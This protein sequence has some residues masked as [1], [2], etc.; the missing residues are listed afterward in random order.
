MKT[1]LY[2]GDEYMNSGHVG[3][4]GCGATVAMKLALRALGEHT[5]MVIPASCWAIIGGNFP[6]SSLKVPILH[7]GFATTAAAASGLRAAL[8][9]RGD[10]ETTV[11]GW[12]GDGGTFDIGFQALSAA[13]ER[14]EDF[15]YVCYDN[16]A[17]TNTGVQRSS[18]TPW[19]ARTMT[20]PGANWKRQQKKNIVEIM[21]AHRIPYAATAS[22][23][24]PEDLERKLKKA[25]LIRSGLRFIHLYSS[26]PTG[27]GF[28]PE[29]TVKVARMAVRSKAFPLY[30]VEDGVKYTI[31]EAGDKPVK[32][33]LRSQSRF[34]HLS[35]QD[36]GL[37]QSRLDI[38]W[39][40][41]MR[42]TAD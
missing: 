19:G 37:I 40:R 9:L 42:K 4:P 38:E 13:A 12:A 30:E 29:N 5:M 26:C 25:V 36:I 3:C 20:T 28:A 6:Q 16:E 2:S 22:I 23:A 10:T 21:A 27:W 35:D 17:Y 34:R 31:N 33:Y 39:E 14:G 1:E 8:D 24:Y 41:L 7:T 11:V 32:E 15:I 18:S